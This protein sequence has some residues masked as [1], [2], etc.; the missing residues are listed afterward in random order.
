[1]SEGL[2]K[3]DRVI[4]RFQ[5]SNSASIQVSLVEWQGA[6]YLDIR[7]VVPSDKPGEQ[8]TF[9]RKGVRINADLVDK[10]Q[11]LLAQVPQVSRENS[12]PSDEDDEEVEK[13]AWV[14]MDKGVLS[15]GWPAWTTT[16]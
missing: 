6:D 10:L 1:M 2:V 11:G 13:G 15:A 7:E 4:G 8:F 12:A 3:E 14:D 5:K 16:R 9:T